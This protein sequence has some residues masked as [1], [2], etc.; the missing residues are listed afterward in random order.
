[1]FYL[2]VMHELVSIGLALMRAYDITK[3]MTLKEA[4]SYVRTKPNASTS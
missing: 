2:I 3:P 4:L 1:M